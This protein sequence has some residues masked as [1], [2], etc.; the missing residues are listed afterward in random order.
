VAIL[1]WKGGSNVTVGRMLISAR[2]AAVSQRTTQKADRP[3]HSLKVHNAVHLKASAVIAPVSLYQ[4]RGSV[5]QLPIAPEHHSAMGQDL[6]V[7]LLLLYK[8]KLHARVEVKL[9]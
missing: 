8:I 4:V 6:S 5:L 7:P 2:P 1:W 9:V 3:A